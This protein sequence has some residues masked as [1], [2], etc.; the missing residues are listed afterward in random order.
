[1][2]IVAAADDDGDGDVFDIVFSFFS[3]HCLSVHLF[4]KHRGVCMMLYA[5]VFSIFYSS[6]Q[7]N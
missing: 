1:M 6:C 7:G 4:D 3:S 5:I 2:D